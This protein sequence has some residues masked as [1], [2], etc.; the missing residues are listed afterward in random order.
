[1]SS[2][3]NG[4]ECSEILMGQRMFIFTTPMEHTL[5]DWKKWSHGSLRQLSN[6]VHELTL[7]KRGWTYGSRD[8]Q[9]LPWVLCILVRNICLCMQ[10]NI[11]INFLHF[12]HPDIPLQLSPF[13]R[14]WH[15][16]CVFSVSAWNVSKM[17]FLCHFD[18][19]EPGSRWNSTS[20]WQRR[21]GNAWRKL[22]VGISYCVDYSGLV[23]SSELWI[24]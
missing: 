22:A 16:K 15:I 23:W 4:W 5:F 24:T 6:L 20:K 10:C 7:A 18:E 17:R 14:M 13:E 19:S 12:D 9:G 2:L 21:G 1:M 3:G 11:K 8:H